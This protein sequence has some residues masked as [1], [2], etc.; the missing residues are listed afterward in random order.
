MMLYTGR[1]DGQNIDIA[2][3]LMVTTTGVIAVFKIKTSV[4]NIAKRAIYVPICNITLQV[5]IL[6]VNVNVALVAFISCKCCKVMSHM[7]ASMRRWPG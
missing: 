1:L 6:A 4:L 2:H 7:R 5:Y 3:E